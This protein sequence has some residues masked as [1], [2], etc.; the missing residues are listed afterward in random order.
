MK[1]NVGDAVDVDLDDDSKTWAPMQ[2]TARIILTKS[3]GPPPWV[4]VVATE[5]HINFDT[6][7]RPWDNDRFKLCAKAETREMKNHITLL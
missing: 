2:T 4:V 1:F 3:Y 7:S 5:T 6:T